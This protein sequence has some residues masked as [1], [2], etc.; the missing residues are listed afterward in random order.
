MTK[1]M[2]QGIAIG[3]FVTT[4]FF[5]YNFY[6]TNSFTIIKE[7]PTE[8]NGDLLEQE[9]E[10]YLQSNDLVAVDKKGYE[11]LLSKVDEIEEVEDEEKVIEQEEDPQKISTKEVSFIIEPG[12]S[13]GT[14]GLMLEEKG[15]INDRN[16]FE[17]FLID[18]GLE[19]KIKAGEYQLSTDMS[20]D[21]IIRQIT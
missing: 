3:I 10:H 16:Q 14:V 20:L 7:V 4:L 19:T 17:N 9:I 8:L 2:L 13:S 15:L 5:A 6:Y 1:K 11:E 12:T 21:E 18:A